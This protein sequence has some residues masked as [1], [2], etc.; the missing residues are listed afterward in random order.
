MSVNFF[1][2]SKFKASKLV[3]TAVFDLLK[4]V[5][6]DFTKNQEGRKMAKYPYFTIS[7]FKNPNQAAQVCKWAMFMK[8]LISTDTSLISFGIDSRSHGKF[9]RGSWNPR[10]PF[11]TSQ[12]AQSSFIAGSSLVEFGQT[13]FSFGSN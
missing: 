5:I 13:S 8:S 10:E 9:G 6:I 12:Q 1:Q 3:K 2:K 11:D 4:S 7:T